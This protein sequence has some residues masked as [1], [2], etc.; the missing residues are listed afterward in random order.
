M[1]LDLNTWMKYFLWRR[2]VG[3]LGWEFSW[4]WSWDLVCLDDDQ[5][6]WWR[7]SGGIPCQ[8]WWLVTGLDLWC[9]KMWVNDVGV[10][11]DGN[12]DDDDL[13][14]LGDDVQ[15]EGKLAGVG[16]KG[17]LEDY[18][19]KWFHKNNSKSWIWVAC[20]TSHHKMAAWSLWWQN[21]ALDCLGLVQQT[22]LQP[23]GLDSS[24]SSWRILNKTWNTW[25]LDN[26]ML[27]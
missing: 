22:T 26:W 9:L 10:G 4:L 13:L 16:N 12:L 20:V 6:W 8:L 7:W 24:W 15:G 21:W 27:D 2:I 17:S 14:D 5:T 1:S 19:L 25:C 11:V 3:H 23:T 18:G